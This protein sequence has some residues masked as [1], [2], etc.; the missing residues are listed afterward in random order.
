MR[1]GGREK[2]LHYFG[3]FYLTHTLTSS[4]SSDRCGLHDIHIAPGALPLRMRASDEH[5]EAIREL[6]HLLGR[7]REPRVMRRAC[8]ADMIH[9][10][11]AEG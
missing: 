3:K 8:D 9:Q 5:S 6:I 4:T 11:K 7:A 1:G 10:E 2:P